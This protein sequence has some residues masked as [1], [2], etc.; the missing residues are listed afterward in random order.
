MSF[1]ESEKKSMIVTPL[2]TYESG[3]YDKAGAEIVTHDHTTQRLFVTND[4]SQTIDVLDISNPKN[5]I[6]EFSIDV[7]PYGNLV[8]SIDVHN[9]IIAAAI[10][11]ESHDHLGKVVFF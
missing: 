2:G 6:L 3:I 1:A 5:P 8:N 11:P 4:H 10:E 9:Q 7:T